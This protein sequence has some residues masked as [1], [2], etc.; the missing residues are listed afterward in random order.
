VTYFY[1]K[2]K[3]SASALPRSEQFVIFL[4]CFR[5]LV[6]YSANRRYK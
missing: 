4:C 6:N 2:L 3:Y 1:V 5:V